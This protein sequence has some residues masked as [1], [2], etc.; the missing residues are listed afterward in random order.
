M[1]R[2]T[3][4]TFNGN[5]R[6]AFAFYR[7]VFGGD[8]SVVQTFADGPPDMSRSEAKTGVPPIATRLQNHMRIT[9]LRRLIVTIPEV[10]LA[11]FTMR[12]V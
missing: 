1:S 11:R 12:E 3:T 10:I 7:S 5:C 4:L 8:F 9:A 6:K 2:N